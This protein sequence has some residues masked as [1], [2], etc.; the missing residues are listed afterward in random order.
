M[1][2]PLVPDLE[3]LTPFNFHACVNCAFYHGG[4]IPQVFGEYGK[5]RNKVQLILVGEAPGETEAESGRPFMGKAGGA[6]RAILAKLNLPSSQCLIT[7]VVK[8]RPDR[9][10]T[11]KQSETT[12]CKALLDWELI[13]FPDVPVVTL[14]KVASNAVLGLN[15]AIGKIQ[16]G[17]FD[18]D[19]RAV[20]PTFHPAYGLRR[21]FALHLIAEDIQAALS[22]VRGT[23]AMPTTIELLSEAALTC[24]RTSNGPF[25]VLDIETEG[26]DGKG[27]LSPFR[28]D[29][30]ISMLG[31]KWDG[32]AHT[33]HFTHPKDIATACDWLNEHADGLRVVGHNLKFDLLWLLQHSTLSEEAVMQFVVWD[34]MVVYNMLDEEAPSIALKSLCMRLFNVPDWSNKMDEHLQWY[35]SMDLALTEKLMHYEAHETAVTSTPWVLSSPGT[36]V[37]T[38]MEYAG[39]NIDHTVLEELRAT[40]GAEVTRLLTLLQ[41]KGLENPNS[42]KQVVHLLCEG[43]KLPVVK[44]T[45]SGAPSVDKEALSIYAEATFVPADVRRLVLDVLEYRRVIKV[46]GTYIKSYYTF[47]A[48]YISSHQSRIHPSFSMTRARTGRLASSSPNFQNQ[49][50][51]MQKSW[52]SRFERGVLFAPDLSQI[53]LR[54][55]AQESQDPELIRVCQGGDLHSEVVDIVLKPRGLGWSIKEMRLA[56]KRINFGIAYLAGAKTIAKQVP[57][58]TEDVAMQLINAWYDKFRGVAAWQERIK[59]MCISKHYVTNLFGRTRHLIGGYRKSKDGEA[60]LRQAVNFPIQSGASDLMVY[61]IMPSLA[62]GLL[63]ANYESR[64]VCNIHDSVIIDTHPEEVEY[65]QELIA[66]TMNNPPLPPMRGIAAGRRWNDISCVPITYE[67]KQ[68]GVGALTEED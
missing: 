17:R 61:G 35:N 42:T 49:T 27:T 5:D 52:T 60:V 40:Y 9:N 13:Q 65:V 33:M 53:E 54:I 18:V 26:G 20:Y 14:G 64:I 41:E 10:R 3:W 16:G 66:R 25:L 6:L 22:N 55:L 51:D 56:A 63:Q 7:N 32:D 39:V 36:G 57:G 34:T 21:P 48:S 43:F 28:P 2:G 44:R 59:D 4:R 19:G 8:C 68:I 24:L 23:A 47:M 11:P 29:C 30:K 31:L 1:N 12:Q 46:V 37:L 62:W 15:S 45:D 38:L 58:L 67:M 50:A